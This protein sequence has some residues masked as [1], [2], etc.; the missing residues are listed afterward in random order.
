MFYVVSAFRGGSS[1][2]LNP[3]VPFGND[4]MYTYFDVGGEKS[5]IMY[6][7]TLT[8]TLLTFLTLVHLDKT[9][10]IPHLHGVF[11]GI[12]S[13]LHEIVKLLRVSQRVMIRIRVVI[14]VRD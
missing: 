9:N 14:K 10:K 6:S 11:C 12:F 5:Y 1:N 7:C 4:T 8:E 2:K 13:D 3:Q